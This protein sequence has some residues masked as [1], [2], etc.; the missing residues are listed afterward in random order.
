MRFDDRF[1]PDMH[2]ANFFARHPMASHADPGSCST[3]HSI[4]SCADCH[5]ARNVAAPGGSAGKP[6]AEPHPPGWIGVRREDNEHGRAARRDPMACAVCHGGAG[7]ALC[8]GCHRVGGVGGSPHAPGWTSTL[9]K[10]TRLPC[11]KCHQ[12]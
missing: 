5:R 11:I 4:D 7:E 10:M 6:V 2:P 9:D 8:V 12:P 1:T 3:C